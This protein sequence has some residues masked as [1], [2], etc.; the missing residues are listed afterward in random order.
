M[1]AC[2]TD[3]ICMFPLLRVPTQVL[4]FCDLLKKNVTD[5][6]CALLFAQLVFIL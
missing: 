1:T 6:K 4:K 5:W 2:H 3:V